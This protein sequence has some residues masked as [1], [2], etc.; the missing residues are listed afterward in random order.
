MMQTS[1]NSNIRV[2]NKVV[3]LATL[4]RM[5]C[6]RINCS[7]RP[8]REASLS[9]ATGFRAASGASDSP[10]RRQSRRWGWRLPPCRAPSPSPC[11]GGRSCVHRDRRRWSRRWRSPLRRLWWASPSWARRNR[12]RRRRRPAG[13]PPSAASGRWG[14]RRARWT[15]TA[16]QPLAAGPR[17]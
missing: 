13:A 16:A 15:C 11:R 17:P 4:Y 8:C 12:R 2:S 10:P 9:R 5:S 6:E 1:V 14:A 3:E 7:E